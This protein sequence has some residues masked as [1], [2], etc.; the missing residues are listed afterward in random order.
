MSQCVIPYSL[1]ELNAEGCTDSGVPVTILK[2]AGVELVVTERG[3]QAELLAVESAAGNLSLLQ[4]D[5]L[6]EV[7]LIDID[8]AL[9]V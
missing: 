6:C 5:Y 4:V 7:G 2:T 3:P 1:V 9:I 8:T